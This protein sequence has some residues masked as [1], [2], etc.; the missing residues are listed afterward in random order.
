MKEK[1]SVLLPVLT[2]TALLVIFARPQITGFVVGPGSVLS[3]DIKITTAEGVILPADS[4]VTATLSEESSSMPVSMFVSKSGGAYEF[5]NGNVPELG[6][7]GWGYTGNHTYIVPLSEFNLTRALPGGEH[8]I[9]VKIEYNGYLIS[10]TE[11]RV[12]V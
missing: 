12:V 4:V 5:V 1:I 11:E 10:S 6:Y 8:S 7:D 9:G 2:I 3:A